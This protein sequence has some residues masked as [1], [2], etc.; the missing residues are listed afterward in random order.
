MKSPPC[1]NASS[2]AFAPP[3]S[4]TKAP[5]PKLARSI[6]VAE[7]IRITVE[8]THAEAYAFA[9]VIRRIAPEEAMSRPNDIDSE[10]WYR[11]LDKL[12]KQ[13]PET[14]PRKDQWDETL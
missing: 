2:V 12:S 10:A 11:A 9:Q 6:P 8:L 5:C 13:L 14:T 1:S 3:L 7:P 4:T